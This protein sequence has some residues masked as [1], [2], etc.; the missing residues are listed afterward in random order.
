[1][2]FFNQVKERMPFAIERI[3]TDRG[4][5]FFAYNVQD[6]LREWKIKFRPIKPA[7]PH[8]N[9][10]V[11]RTQRTDLDEFYSSISISDPELD[12]KLR[13]WEEYYN[14]H[15]S[16]SS[17]QGKTPFEK[18]K[19]LESITRSKADIESAYDPNK[20]Q[21]AVQNYKHDQIL[22]VLRARQSK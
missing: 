22:K 14:K 8:L 9:G 20:E 19:S 10:K 12:N 3:Q 11:E 17:L 16:H 1:M 5:E 21:L 4:R 7:S 15:R 6:L 13:D 2:H 18:Y